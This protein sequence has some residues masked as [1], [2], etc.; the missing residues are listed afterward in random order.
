[1]M[2]SSDARTEV[3]Q[4]GWGNA[5]YEYSDG[6]MISVQCAGGGVLS[7]R[8]VNIK[9]AVF[10]G[11]QKDDIIAGGDTTTEDVILLPLCP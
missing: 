8:N 11:N 7:N 1:M 10:C 9:S 3:F 5:C 6:E 2:A 4:N